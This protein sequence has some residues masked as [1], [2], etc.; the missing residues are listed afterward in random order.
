M[1]KKKV[2]IVKF[3]DKRESIKKVLEIS[4]CLEKING[5][6]PSDK[7][8]VKPNLVM[9][10][11]VY[12]FPKYGVITTSVVV[13]ETVR[14]LAEAGCR[15]I[16]IA[17]G[18]VENE[19]IGSSLAAAF[20]GLGYK[21]LKEKYGVKLANFNDGQFEKVDF[22]PYS[23]R[24]ANP[25]LEADFIVNLPVL[26]THNS[27]KVSLGFKNLKG[28]LSKSSKSFCHHTELDLDLF[29][30][31]FAEKMYPGVTLI[32]GIYAL[33]RGPVFNGKAYRA[34]VLVASTD[35]FA[36]DAVGS[37]IL[38][39][40]VEEIEHLK[41]FAVRK[42]RPLDLS[43][44]EIVGERLEDVQMP[45]EWDWPWQEDDSGPPAM[46]RMGI[47]GVFFP[48]YDVTICSGCSFLNNMLLIL[49]MGA[50]EGKPFGNIEFLSGKKRLSA[51]GYDKT[52][53]FGNCIERAN[54][55]NP[56]IREAVHIKGCPP[57]PETIVNTLRAHGIKADLE[58]YR[59][60]RQ[61]IYERY[62][63]KPEFEES[64]YTVSS[65]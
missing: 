62:M 50:Y 60:Y 37:K 24:I 59:R 63:G 38:G 5:L 61:S 16:T 52:F 7:V 42:G 34:D 20:E 46:A 43:D 15:D 41:D 26:K 48:K 32:D 14:L 44:I 33:E 31:R 54:R 45:L 47:K 29:I 17:E 10:D 27:T 28:A 4:G 65:M 22:G 18:P 1:E 2:G 64:H 55:N 21:R 9:W 30:S 58:S 13:E 40:P 56:H 8:I 23:L 39:Y 11:T 53:L 57:S 51:G 19:G 3:E 25:V 36:A 35:M 49:L 6:A 12:P